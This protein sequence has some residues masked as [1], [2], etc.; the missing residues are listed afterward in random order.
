MATYPGKDIERAAQAACGSASDAGAGAFGPSAPCAGCGAAALTPAQAAAA[1]WDGPVA[2]I[3]A[4]EPESPADDAGFTAGCYLTTV[5]GQPVRDII[6][7][8]WLAAED[9]IAVGYID[10]D[11]EA[12]DRKSVV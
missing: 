5:D 8:R 6:D 11:G 7:W 2:P 1:A 9:A 12:G 10:L 4:V 3:A